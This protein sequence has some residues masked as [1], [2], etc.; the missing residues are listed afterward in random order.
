MW[1]VWIW[2]RPLV[3]CTRAVT[4][5][6]PM[7]EFRKS[8]QKRPRYKKPRKSAH[9]SVGLSIESTPRGTWRIF[10]L[11]SAPVSFFSCSGLLPTFA[12]DLPKFRQGFAEVFFGA[13][14]RSHPSTWKA[15]K[16]FLT[17]RTG[18]GNGGPW[19]FLHSCCGKASGKVFLNFCETFWVFAKLRRIRPVSRQDRRT[20]YRKLII[21]KSN[22]TTHSGP[23]PDDTWGVPD[24]VWP[25]SG[26][27]GQDWRPAF[28]SSGM[29]GP[30]LM[31]IRPNFQQNVSRP[32]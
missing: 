24:D 11:F 27:D 5:Y 1:F 23:S 2:V 7:P 30:I 10:F 14:K 29:A 3:K 28:R 15:R 8:D 21:S 9:P 12:E 4:G 13:W 25:P 32:I 26:T 17:S 6:N 31:R 20:G 16:C 22:E 18:S 19:N